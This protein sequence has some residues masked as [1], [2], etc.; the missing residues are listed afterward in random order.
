MRIEKGSRLVSVENT[1]SP[2]KR[3]G[4][5]AGERGFSFWQVDTEARVRL[6]RM[7][8]AGVRRFSLPVGF[9]VCKYYL[10]RY[11][12]RVYAWLGCRV[13]ES[14]VIR[15]GSKAGNRAGS[16]VGGGSR[17]ELTEFL[18]HSGV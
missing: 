11:V 3:A 15:R 12:C 7:G 2:K 14:R 5:V 1:S 13:T 6:E 17:G 4:F 9:M 16:R 10:P 8:Q 18:P